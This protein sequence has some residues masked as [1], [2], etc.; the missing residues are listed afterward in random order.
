MSNIIRSLK[1]SMQSTLKYIDVLDKE[2]RSKGLSNEQW[3]LNWQDKLNE[4]S[5]R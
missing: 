3:F 2:A 4:I 1:E 5:V